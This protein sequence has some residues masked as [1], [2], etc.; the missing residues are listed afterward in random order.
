[1]SADRSRAHENQWSPSAAAGGLQLVLRLA[2]RPPRVARRALQRLRSVR[3]VGRRIRGGRVAARRRRRISRRA[4]GGVCVDGHQRAV[5]EL[6]HPPVG[7]ERARGAAWSA[8]AARGRVGYGAVGRAASPPRARSPGRLGS[9]SS[10]QSSGSRAAPRTA[11]ARPA[12]ASSTGAR[13]FG[14]PESAGAVRGHSATAGTA[15][16]K[17]PLYEFR[18]SDLYRCCLH[19]RRRTRSTARLVC[20]RRPPTLRRATPPGST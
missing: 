9:A 5:G 3:Q 10:L 16:S 11:V 8:A 6:H 7:H 20:S 15:A 14:R 13:T 1:M 12:T 4:R 18:T 2:I 17:T 19:R